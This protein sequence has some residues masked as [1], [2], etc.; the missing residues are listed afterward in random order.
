MSSPPDEAVFLPYPTAFPSLAFTLLMRTRHFDP[1]VADAIRGA[2]ELVVPSLPVPEPTLLT[3]RIDAQLSEQRIFARLLAL[4][5]GLAVLLAAVGL[6]GVI[7]FAVAGRRRE[8]G[9]RLALG[10][11]Q[12]RIARLVFGSASAIVTVGTGLGLVGAYGLSQVLA[13]RLFGVPALDAASY[14][15]AALLLGTVA[16]LACWAP[17][18][19]AVRVDPVAT[20][21]QD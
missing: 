6:Y 15:G 7:A 17:A 9:I 11:D 12:A 10:A 8:F 20:L 14:A 21:R 3:D 18:R 19:A 1:G 2:V 5:S 13:S 4:L 16:L